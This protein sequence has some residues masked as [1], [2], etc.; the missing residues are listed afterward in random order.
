MMV[1][2]L[3]MNSSSSDVLECVNK[4][5]KEKSDDELF[6]NPIYIITDGK[7]TL[8]YQHRL[9]NMLEN[10]GTFRVS[11]FT[12]NR[13]MWHVYNEIGAGD[14]IQ[15]SRDAHALLLYRIITENADNE[16]MMYFTNGKNINDS[17]IRHIAF[18][19]EV[20]KVIEELED[21][22]VD[23]EITVYLEGLINN[24][25][26]APF[27]TIEKLKA[28]K[29]VYEQYQAECV[30]VATNNSYSK[31]S[32]ISSINLLKDFVERLEQD[33]FSHIRAFKEAEIFIEG[34]TAFKPIE[35]KLLNILNDYGLEIHISE[36]EDSTDEVLKNTEPLLFEADLKAD[37][38]SLNT[39]VEC[40]EAP[41]NRVEY[42]VIAHKI[43]R[44]TLENQQLSFKDIVVYY[45]DEKDLLQLIRTFDKYGIPAQYD[46]KKAITTHPFA[47]FILG[48]FEFANITHK[49]CHHR[50]YIETM[51]KIIKTKYLTSSVLNTYIDRIDDF[52]HTYAVTYQEM[53]DDEKQFSPKL[54]FKKKYGDK[55]N[56]QG[57]KTLCDIALELFE[58]RTYED[59]IKSRK[60]YYEGLNK[61]TSE[62]NM[63]M[64]DEVSNEDAADIGQD[65]VSD[66]EVEIKDTNTDESRV[67]S[68]V[69]TIVVLNH[70]FN[71]INAFV[72]I[73]KVEQSV[74]KGLDSINEYLKNQQIY[75]KLSG[76]YAFYEDEQKIELQQIYNQFVNMIESGYV[77]FEGYNQSQ[78]ALRILT[79]MFNTIFEKGAYTSE[80]KIEDAV[81][82]KLLDHASM[83]PFKHA[84]IANFDR[85]NTP[86]LVKDN[87]ILSDDVKFLANGR[88]SL[89][90]VER[91]ERD[92][93]LVYQAIQ[94]AEKV[95]MSY[96]TIN[97]DGRETKESPILTDLMRQ[98]DIKKYSD[99]Y[100]LYMNSLDG[101]WIEKDVSDKEAKVTIHQDDDYKILPP[102]EHIVLPL[103]QH[104][105]GIDQL[106]DSNNSDAD[107]TWHQVL[108]YLK[109][110]HH[111]K[112]QQLERYYNFYAKPENNQIDHVLAHNL[113]LS[114][115]RRESDD[116]TYIFE[117][118]VSRY[119]LY[120]GCAFK[121]F[122]QYGLNLQTREPFE[123]QSKEI[124]SIQHAVLERF[125]KDTQKIEELMIAVSGKTDEQLIQ[126][127]MKILQDETALYYKYQH[128][129]YNEWSIKK[130]ARAILNAIK[131][132][133]MQLSASNFEPTYF[134]KDFGYAA[135]DS[136]HA[137]VDKI[138][139]T[140]LN[141]HQKTYN[142]FI[143]G[144]IDRVDIYKQ[145]IDGKKVAFV[146]VIDYKLSKKTLE[147]QDILDGGQ[148]Q[149]FSY[150]YIIR[151]NKEQFGLEDCDEVLPSTMMFHPVYNVSPEL[152]ERTI[153]KLSEKTI[154]EVKPDGMFINGAKIY[155]K[156]IDFEHSKAILNLV[157]KKFN[158]DNPK[159]GLNS[160]KDNYPAEFA[161]DKPFKV[162]M[163]REENALKDKDSFKLIMDRNQKKYLSMDGF[164]QVME[165]VKEIYKNNTEQIFTGYVAA[166]PK[167]DDKGELH[168]CKFC[169]FK[170]VCYF[171]LNN[172]N[173]RKYDSENI[174]TKIDNVLGG[175]IPN[176]Y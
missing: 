121:H 17:S 138:E 156:E 45:R 92:K 51:I 2:K 164:E 33:D 77:G 125:F 139:S 57:N 99:K 155:N 148:L 146:N 117:P 41:N 84:F 93:F 70:V 118:S 9:T 1:R 75:A 141:N 60:A 176:E 131:F 123:I 87:Q 59:V 13:L 79:D 62:G 7:Q 162:Y 19:Y 113:F 128:S 43:Y 165:Y 52:V 85:N 32:G 86:K 111:D 136:E 10:N 102:V 172:S 175:C 89:T 73:F 116:G 81:Q 18:A 96:S 173:T 101:I 105:E 25:N 14:K 50:D 103:I 22:I 157:G 67:Q 158:I 83:Q 90:T 82:I 76:Q 58:D 143:K 106:N 174:T 132:S 34:I 150:M 69:D 167:E 129:H 72:D 137:V 16:A 48:L 47:Q 110:N 39:D 160:L 130:M 147:L 142:I 134:E 159:D 135:K 8:N 65:K 21:Y 63:D 161:G 27:N 78:D 97:H 31:V 114:K 53:M 88:L 42:D 171:D 4:Q 20:L 145:E 151:N 153:A 126:D 140:E 64:E 122:A 36:A 98:Y 119:Q 56:E 6:G 38:V 30:K 23:Q 170:S 109:D 168:P 94:S 5:L 55:K 112:Y 28:I 152:K 104:I 144:Q 24:S 71:Q 66:E 127:I 29:F 169:D 15:V 11:V 166:E 74:S 100:R 68:F 54:L 35:L 115:E 124:G 40:F 95:T 12:F 108:Q 44:D 149:L 61:D 120:N 26:D 163:S 154:K 3:L 133:L 91:A 49:N 37:E 46:M 107:N 80:R